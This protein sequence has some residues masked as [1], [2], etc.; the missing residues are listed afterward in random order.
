MDLIQLQEKLEI[1]ND[2][3]N[4]V[5]I[6]LVDKYG[7]NLN[8]VVN[9]L[10][11]LN[12]IFSREPNYPLC[13]TEE[14]NKL[15]NYILLM[16]QKYSTDFVKSKINSIKEILSNNITDY[17]ELRKMNRLSD[18][19][20]SK[21]M[22]KTGYKYAPSLNI[23]T[24][25]QMINVL[26]EEC[27]TLNNLLK[28]E[29]MLPSVNETREK[30]NMYSDY[31]RNVDFIVTFN[32]IDNLYKESPLLQF[33]FDEK[34]LLLANYILESDVNVK[35]KDK[36][37]DLTKDIINTSINIKHNDFFNGEVNLE[38]YG[39]LSKHTL[40][41]IRNYELRREEEKEK[42]KDVNL[43]SVEEKSFLDSNAIYITMKRKIKKKIL[44]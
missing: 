35:T 31:A 32:L 29:S 7:R 3:N 40:E 25:P 22:N 17:K 11:K 18:E 41:N 39:R 34:Y 4:L 26:Y 38:E 36:I 6:Q 8:D 21:E 10:K 16:D 28:K 9:F 1:K 5:G 30:Y 2:I 12:V 42:E 37:V 19:A 44:K 24:Y 27:K 14:H 23:K 33:C 43:V 20:I 15:I 13:I